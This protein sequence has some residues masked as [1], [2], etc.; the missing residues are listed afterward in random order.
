LGPAL[1]GFGGL[2]KVFKHLAQ[3]DLQGLHIA[4]FKSPVHGSNVRML[5]HDSPYQGKGQNLCGNLSQLRGTHGSSLEKALNTYLHVYVHGEVKQV[6]LRIRKTASTVK[7]LV[8]RLQNS[9]GIVPEF[10]GGGH[11]RF[12]SASNSFPHPKTG[13]HGEGVLFADRASRSKGFY[14]GV[15]QKQ[16]DSREGKLHRDNNRSP[17]LPLL[18]VFEPKPS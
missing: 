14:H 15:F 18:I 1:A 6:I 11:Y 5:N 3:L 2:G 7:G 16:A 13:R 17:P 9:L 4:T 8:D 12:P 10:F